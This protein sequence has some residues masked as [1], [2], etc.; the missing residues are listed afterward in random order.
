MTGWV[1]SPARLIVVLSAA[2]LVGAVFVSPGFFIIDEV[3]YVLGLD[4][5]ARTGGYV[6]ENGYDLFGAND[7][8]IW[9]LQ[10][11]AGGIVSQYPAGT[12]WAGT[13]LLPLFGA[14]ALMALNVLAG[15]GTLIV[16][17][18]LALELFRSEKIG[19]LT[20]L[21]LGL[22][23]FWAEYVFG[24]WPHSVSVFL[25]TLA[26][27]LVLRA[28]PREARAFLPAVLSGLAIGAGM[29]FRLDGILVAPGIAVVA[30]LWAVRPVIV[31]AGGAAGLAPMIALLALTN[32]A[33]FG[34]WNPLTYG[35]SGGTTDLSSHLGTGVVLLA[36]LAGLFLLRRLPPLGPQARS[37]LALGALVVLGAVLLSPAAPY[38]WKLLHGIWAIL[39]DATAIDD[40]RPGVRRQPDGTLLFWGLPKKALFQSL[41]WLG[42][43][44][45][46]AGRREAPRRAVAIVL[47]VSVLWA[48]PFLAKSWHGGLGSNMRYLMP[49]LPGLAALAAWAILDLMGRL[50]AASGL[51]RVGILVPLVLAM[52]LRLAAPEQMAQVHQVYSTWAFV[53]VFALSLAAGFFNAPVLTRAALVG[54]GA[55]LGLALYLGAIDL[56]ASQ[57]SRAWNDAVSRATAGIPG[58]VILYGAPELYVNA[59]GVPDRLL[60]LSYPPD[61]SGN[62]TPDFVAQAC[63]QGYKTVLW[64]AS[65]RLAGFAPERLVPLELAL[66]TAE[67]RLVSITCD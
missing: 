29:L 39:F 5:F 64:E 61:G 21:L 11:G 52:L 35:V 2:L 9:L 62:I 31:L 63:A 27:L 47:I 66:P 34:S 20:V 19:F 3:V 4:A 48:L 67:G 13:L 51:I 65:A 43:L 26:L 18:L 17:Y 37:G 6:V 16:T 33:K 41:P 1:S 25:T 8:K 22:F 15:I 58:P 49:I 24:H 40:P 55:G 60:A 45:Y 14:K 28:L 46:L 36:G 23:S 12:A 30:I 56:A 44:G 38:L 7:F 53:A 59:V 42:V 54:V 57:K 32:H 10:K 50:E